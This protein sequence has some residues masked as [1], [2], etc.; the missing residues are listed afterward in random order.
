MRAACGFLLL[1]SL[2]PVAAPPPGTISLFAGGANETGARADALQL[3]PGWDNR[4]LSD[5]AGG[6]YVVGTSQPCIRYVSPGGVS[7]L[8]LGTCFPY[9]PFACVLNGP[10]GDG[11]AATSALA[12]S[13][14]AM[15]L[16]SSGLFFADAAAARV[17]FVSFSSG[18]VNTVVGNATTCKNGVQRA[19]AVGT[20]VCLGAPSALALSHN[21]TLLYIGDA[22]GRFIAAFSPA[23]GMVWLVAGTP[24][25]PM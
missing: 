3:M 15:A 13:P 24:A 8:V 17:R 10:N 25:S 1:L 23:S 18:V 5:N 6:F 19:P 21:G 12:C 9:A 20:T 4:A 14:R 2:P 22:G 7:R 16:N 11:G